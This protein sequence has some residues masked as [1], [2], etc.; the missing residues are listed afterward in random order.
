M[1]SILLLLAFVAA[2]CVS[3]DYGKVRSFQPPPDGAFEA[4]V[5]G[6][7]SVDD[8]V[9]SLGAP[10]QVIEVGRGLAL[11]WG[12]QKEV[13]W[14]VQVS[15]P[16]GDVQGSVSYADTVNKLPGIVLFFDPEWT[17]LLK[18]RGFLGDLLP[19]RQPPRDVDD[20]LLDADPTPSERDT[21]PAVRAPD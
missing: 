4:L 18:R 21:P 7:S 8:A 16:I 13:G 15:A 14:E 6:E 17:L 1:R 12:W 19:N 11:S 20:D 5:V 2:S 9:A 10:L 3:G